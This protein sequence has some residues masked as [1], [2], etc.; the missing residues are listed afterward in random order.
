MPA[1]LFAEIFPI[2][3]DALPPL[4]AYRILTRNDSARKVGARLAAELREVF[5]GDWVWVGGRI[6]TDQAPNPVKLVMMLDQLKPHFRDVEA[7]E[8]DFA[9]QPTADHLADF[10]ARGPLLRLEDR[11]IDALAKTA[12]GIKNTRT[13]REYRI[14]TWTVDNQPA[15]SI[16]VVSRLLYEPDLQA[17]V[18]TL[19][20]PTDMIGL[21]VAD[22]TARLQG[23]ITKVVGTLDEQRDRLIK[24][25]DRPDMQELLAKTPGDHWVCRVLVDTREYDYVTDALDL[26]IRLRDIGQFDINK[27][28]MEKALHLSPALHAQMVKLI[29]DILKEHNLI[30]NAYSTQNAA[31]LFGSMT[32]KF[33]LAYGS[34]KSRP[35]DLARLNQDFQTAGA[36]KLPDTDKPLRVVVINTLADEVRDF[37]EAL[38][39]SL[40]RDFGLKLEVVRE[41]S[42]RVI[43][44]ANLESAVR[45][46][47]KEPH[48][49][50]LAFLPDEIESAEEEAVDDRNTR[51]QTVGRGMPTLVI[52]E[53]TMNNP[54][55][56]SSVIMG[57]VARAGGI[58][59]LLDESLPY[60][61]RVVGLSLIE[62]NKKD[63]PH[64]TGVARV[65]KKDGAFIGYAIATEPVRDGASVP[66][67][68]LARLLPQELL[69]GKRVVLHLDGKQRREVLR[70]IGAWEG[71]IDAEF[72]PVEV[73]RSG[74][75]RI[76]ALGGGKIEAPDWGSTFRL[77]DTEAFILTTSGDAA[78]QPIHIRTEASLPI[79]QA[80]HSVLAFTL[81]HYGA[82]KVPKLPV[83]LY[84]GDAL[85]AGILRGVLDENLQGKTQF[86]L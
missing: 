53:S 45:L 3:T 61:D 86:W 32:P 22:K 57:L 48:D 20:K 17:Y 49:L 18:E 69:G 37:T 15:L 30:S 67:A 31:A 38:R 51:L 70:A 81:F 84:G 35:Y 27:A 73:I 13:Q 8:E 25:S 66:D 11:L 63:V 47:L 65:Y 52:H 42:I 80:L 41:R 76:Y 12:Y 71:E 46:L 39:R 5:P 34:G 83:T 33:S 21:W 75:P 14:R 9:W 60:A 1:H 62:H 85:E 56:M 4:T 29:S 64:L 68:L 28:Q 79:E 59:Y 74:V 10:V 40:D 24:L 43:S 78:I 2:K 44:Q 7:L 55:A 36:Q 16:T 19:D 23:E 54:A 50:A 58:P 72:C 82:V 6:L 26:V 77:S